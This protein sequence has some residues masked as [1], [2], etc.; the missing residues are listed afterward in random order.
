MDDHHS[1]SNVIERLEEAEQLKLIG[2][3]DNALVIL[4][5]LLVED[6]ENVSALEEVADNELSLEH[7]PRAEAAAEQ[8]ISLDTKSYTAHYIL[9]F[10]RS[11]EEEW[12]KLPNFSMEYQLW[13]DLTF[14]VFPPYISVAV[15]QGTALACDAKPRTSAQQAR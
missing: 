13:F 15:A 2:E 7:F 3:Y 11:Q 14:P 1:T 12:T 4:E 10:L 6:P 8:A 5:Q 9:G